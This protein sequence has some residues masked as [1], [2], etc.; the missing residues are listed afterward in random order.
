M[1]H[2]LLVIAA[3]AVMEIN[4]QP[5]LHFNYNPSIGTVV[6]TIPCDTTNVD[7]GPAGANQTWIFNLTTIGPPVT[8]EYVHPAATG[9]NVSY[10]PSADVALQDDPEAFDHDVYFKVDFDSLVY[11]G[12]ADVEVETYSDGRIELIYPFMYGD[13]FEDYYAFVQPIIGPFYATGETNVSYDAYGTLII[14]GHSFENVIR[15]HSFSS[16]TFTGSPYSDTYEAYKWIDPNEPGQVILRISTWYGISKYVRVSD[17]A[18]SVDQDLK[19]IDFDVFPTVVHDGVITLSYE[20][21]NARC[22]TAEI[23]DALGR[24]IF[25]KQSQDQQE[26]SFKLSIPDLPSGVYIVKLK[27]ENGLVGTR[28]ILKQ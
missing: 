26:K 20:C 19:Q 1:R 14:N 7:P 2:I 17:F 5:V 10:F 13:S 25:S 12:L 22:I 6:T 27:N 15:V 24:R 3:L 28:R 9:G 4:A 8:R 21:D 11:L 18:V 23:Y 16:H